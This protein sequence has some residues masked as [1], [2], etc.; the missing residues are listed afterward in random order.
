M[1]TCNAGDVSGSAVKIK[2][3]PNSED[4]NTTAKYC[5]NNFILILC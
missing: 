3:S 4:L 1:S 2:H 5:V